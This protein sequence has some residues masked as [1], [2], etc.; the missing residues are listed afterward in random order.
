MDSAP[1]TRASTNLIIIKKKKLINQ[2]LMQGTE[3]MKLD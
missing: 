3:E 1:V 2:L